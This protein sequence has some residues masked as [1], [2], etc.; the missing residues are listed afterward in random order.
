MHSYFFDFDYNNS[1]VM[2]TGFYINLENLNIFFLI[3]NYGFSHTHKKI[4]GRQLCNII[5]RTVVI[6]LYYAL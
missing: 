6:T 4:I 1:Y 2:N 3:N 5:Y